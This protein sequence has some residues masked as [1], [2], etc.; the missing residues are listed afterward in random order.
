MMVIF[1]GSLVTTH[2]FVNPMIDIRRVSGS[3]IL[4]YI[5][6]VARLRIAV[7]REFPYLYDGNLA[8]EENYL[9]RYTQSNLTVI[10]LALDGQQV[11]G[12]STGMP[13][14]DEGPAVREPFEIGGFAL[15]DI[16]YFGESVLLPQYRG[17]GI[18]VRFFSERE[19][20]ALA[21]GFKTTT[22]CAVH[23]PENHPR[24]PPGYQPLDQFWQKRGYT[25]Q[26][27]M[28][29][30]FRWRDLD[31]PSESPKTLIYWIKYH[32]G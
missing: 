27:N 19:A 16:F 7:F 31:E 4:P 3:E 29:S 28:K 23:R 25:R 22:F 24:R 13:L 1:E 9:R 8:Y 32:P 5:Q 20:H 17:R 18:G 2:V 26:T 10:T 12:A 6:D 11:I 15:E 30:T 14:D 21:H